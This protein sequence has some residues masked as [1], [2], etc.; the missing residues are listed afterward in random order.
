MTYIARIE[1]EEG[2][3]EEFRG[4]SPSKAVGALVKGVTLG[5]KF[6]LTLAR[7]KFL[8]K[9]RPICGTKLEEWLEPENLPE[10]LN[11]FLHEAH[12]LEYPEFIACTIIIMSR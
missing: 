4:N 10:A 5:G 1:N 7:K 9:E 8:Q 2:K 11:D 3:K 6:S 12:C